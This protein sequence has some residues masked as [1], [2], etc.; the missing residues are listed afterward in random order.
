M[1]ARTQWFNGVKYYEHKTGYYFRAALR[2]GRV[3]S[4]SMHRTVWEHH[5]G[6]IP[7]GFNIHHINHE[8]GDNRIENLELVDAREHARR[9]LLERVASGDLD[10]EGSLAKAQ[11]AAKAWHRSEEGRA[12]HREHASRIFADQPRDAHIC[13]QCEGTYEGVTKHRKRGFCSAKCQSAARRDSGV[14]D[15]ERKCVECGS[16]FTVNRYAKTK[17]CGPSCGGRVASRKRLG[18]RPDS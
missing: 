8:R 11:E 3:G 1:A 5:N 10:V 2:E 6:P 12:W 9:H 13:V 4:R 14:D 7:D 16:S 17:C 18:V 15:V